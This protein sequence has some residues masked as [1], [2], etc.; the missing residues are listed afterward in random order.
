M[1]MGQNPGTLGTLRHSWLMDGYSPGHMAISKVLPHFH[2]WMEPR[3][4]KYNLITRIFWRSNQSWDEPTNNNKHFLSM[5][6]GFCHLVN[7]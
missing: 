1:V 4:L 7:D 2:F 6:G 3:K 5:V